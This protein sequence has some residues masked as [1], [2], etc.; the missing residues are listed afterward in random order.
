MA[1]EPVAKRFVHQTRTVLEMIKFGLIDT[2]PIIFIGLPCRIAWSVSRM[3]AG[4][5][6]SA[7]IA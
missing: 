3:S 6:I 7:R 5:T 2:K 1:A 4:R